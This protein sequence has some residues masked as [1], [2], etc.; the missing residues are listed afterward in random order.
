M[1]LKKKRASYNSSLVA[2]LLTLEV[3]STDEALIKC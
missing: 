3:V 2:F 1:Q